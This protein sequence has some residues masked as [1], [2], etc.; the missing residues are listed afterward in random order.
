MT[1]TDVV[2]PGELSLW[3][4]DPFKPWVEAGKI[5]GRGVEDNQQDLV[6]S[7]FAVKAFQAAGSSPIT[8]SAWPLSPTKKRAATKGIAYVLKHSKA[9][10]PRT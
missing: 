1:H 6:A 7:I 10:R 3:S 4:G 9:F 5:F 2:P 8:T